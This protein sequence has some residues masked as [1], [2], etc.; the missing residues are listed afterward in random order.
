M[1]GHR[2]LW[3][4]I[5][6]AGQ[7]AVLLVHRRYLNRS[8]YMKGWIGW[9]PELPFTGELVTVTGQEERRLPV[10]DIRIWPGHLALLPDRRF[11]LVKGRTF[12]SETEGAWASNAVVFSPSGTPEAEFCVGDDI[13]ALV[14]DAHGGIWTAYGDEGIYGGHPESG[15]GL[16][17]WDT[18]GRTTWTPRG[19]LPDHPLEGCTA[20]TEYGHVWLV[21]Y[22]GNSEGGTFLTRITPST[23]DVASYPSPVP[24]PDGL[25]I[26]GNRAVLTRRHHNK[27][28]VDLIRAELDGTTWT[29][30]SHRR[31]RVPGRVVMTCGQGRDGSLLLR[32]GDTWLRIEA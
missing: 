15:A 1:R 13:P 25:A 32:T 14:T 4:T 17:G 23:G 7:L 6:P 27:R 18:Q 28:S 8:R 21:W 19:R 3:W 31:L 29:V 24:D 20:A 5:G 16:A 11:L 30:T 22:S 10:K 2:A 12:R 26:R 9:R